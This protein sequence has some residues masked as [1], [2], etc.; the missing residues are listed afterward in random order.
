MKWYIWEMVTE[1][2]PDAHNKK[3]KGLLSSMKEEE[4]KSMEQLFIYNQEILKPLWLM[5]L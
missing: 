2:Y 4:W 5:Q 3:H 1:Y